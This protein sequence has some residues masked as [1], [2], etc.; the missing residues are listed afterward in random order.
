MIKLKQKIPQVGSK[1]YKHEI[2]NDTIKCDFEN[3]LVD[4][5]ITLD[6]IIRFGYGHY[7]LSNKSEF[8]LYAGR[9]KIKDGKIIYIDTDSGHYVPTEEEMLNAKEILNKMKLI[10]DDVKLFVV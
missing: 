2:I 4:F 1:I 3:I 7:K 9:A 5:V 6:G 8:V 10:S